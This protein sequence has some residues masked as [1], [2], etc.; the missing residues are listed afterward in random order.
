MNQ[1]P[2]AVP[3]SLE[4]KGNLLLPKHHSIADW[5]F[6]DNTCR[7]LDPALYISEPSSL[8]MYRPGPTEPPAVIALCR[9][10]ET[11]CL[12]QGELRTWA[13][14]H[15]AAGEIVLTFRNQ[16]ALG[17]SNA[18]N[19]YDWHIYS[20]FAQCVSR[21]G[22]DETILGSVPLT[23]ETDTWYHWRCCWWNGYT[24][25]AEEAICME[26]YQEEA[27][28]WIKKGDT[29]YDTNNHWKDSEVNRVG[30]RSCPTYTL[31]FYFDDTEIWG[32]A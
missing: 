1:K 31:T 2:K 16:A 3:I 20:P 17:T 13:R 12:P 24:P 9:I 8:R 19:E 6:N 15:V 11:Q 10:A 30:I 14:S 29:I 18:D 26:F 25:E 28:E 5:D 21:V 4:R 27:G 22:G 32:P 7:I 23:V